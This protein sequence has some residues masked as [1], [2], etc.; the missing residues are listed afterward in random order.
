MD[1]LA[2]ITVSE[3]SPALKVV[4]VLGGVIALFVAVKVGKVIIRLLFGL[5]GLALLAG[6]VCWFL[7]GR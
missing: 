2:Q 4:T 3:F 6:L 7:A 5:I 1:I